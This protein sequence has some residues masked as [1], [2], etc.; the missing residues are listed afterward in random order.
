MSEFN[1]CI[2]IFKNGNGVKLLS[3]VSIRILKFDYSPPVILFI[4]TY[5]IFYNL[6]FTSLFV[7][8]R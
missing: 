7:L 8:M 1:K 5:R 3:E 2:L 6:F 4:L